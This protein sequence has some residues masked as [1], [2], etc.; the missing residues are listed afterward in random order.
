MADMARSACIFTNID[1]KLYRRRTRWW[2]ILTKS[3]LYKNRNNKNLSANPRDARL[4]RE[5]VNE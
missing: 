3:A 4:F 5:N 1:Y 2:L